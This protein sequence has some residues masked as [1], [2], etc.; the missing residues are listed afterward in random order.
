MSTDFDSLSNRGEYMSAHYFAEQMGADLRKTLFG[1]WS[2]RETDKHDPRPTPREMVRSLRATYLSPE[3]RTFFAE[4]ADVDAEDMD[5]TADNPTAHARLSTY[6]DPIWRQRLTDWHRRVL[7]ALGFTGDS[8]Q[9]V[10]VHRGG[11]EHQVEVAWRDGDLLALECGWSDSNDT[12]LDETRAGLTLHPPHVSGGE[13]Y[14]TGQRLAAWLFQST[15]DSPEGS[16]PRFVLLLCGGVIVL[17]DRHTWAEGRYLAANLDAA[18]ERYD[19][20]KTGE[21]ATIAALFSRDMLVP[22]DDGKGPLIDVL[23]GKSNDNAIGVT[24][25]LR[26]GL[27]LSVEIIANEVLDRLAEAEVAPR[28]IE[29]LEL[30]FAQELTRECLRYLY[31][32]LFLLYAEARPE[33]GI[34]PAD[35]GTY[36]AGY[37]V[38]RLRDLV[39]RDEQ[40]VEEEAKNG[41][42]LFASLEI[43]FEKVNDGHRPYGTEPDDDQPGDDEETRRLKAKR[44]S[45]GQGLRFE[46][47]RSKL[48]EP[49]AIRLIGQGVTDPRDDGES[50]RLDLRLRNSALHEVLRLLTMKKAQKRGERG[51]FISYRNL[52][53]NQ[54]G[55]VYESLMSYTGIIAEEE[56]CEVAKGGKP[57]KG[58]WLIPA[59]QQRDHQG[60][61]VEYG[62]RDAVKGLRGVKRY[63]AGT[64]V[65]RLAGRA[66]E[67]S[68]SYYTPESLTKV[69]VELALK[70][71]LDQ[72]R[73]TEGEIVRTRASELLRYKICEPALGSGAFLN[74]AINQVAEEYLRRRQ[75]ELGTSIPTSDALAEKQKVKAY[76]ALHNAYGVDLNATG[77]ELAEVSLWLNTMHP[78]MRAP[79]FGLHLRRGNSLVGARRV[80][81][82][83]EEVV[84]SKEWLRDKNTLAPTPLPFVAETGSTTLPEDAVHQFLLPSPGWASVTRAGGGARKLVNELSGENMRRLAQW[85]KDILRRPRRSMAHLDKQGRPKFDPK[86]GEPKKEAPSQ[87]TRL[88]D[89]ARK[90]E[91]LWSLVVKRMEIS[92]NEIARRIDVWGAKE[93]DPEYAFLQRPEGAVPK[94]KVYKDLFEAAGTP[95]WRLKKV[96]DAWCALWFW[97]VDK[98]DLLDGTDDEYGG[99]PVINSVD[100]VSELLDGVPVIGEQVPSSEDG[101][102]S[103]ESLEDAEAPE[104]SPPKSEPQYYERLP[105]FSLGSEQLPLDNLDPSEESEPETEKIRAKP[106]SFGKGG[107]KPQIPQRRPKIPLKDLDDWLDFLEA[108]LGVRDIPEGTLIDQLE[109]LDQLQELEENL[110]DFMGMEK[111]DPE[112]HFPWLST[113][114]DITKE[115]GFL[116]WE[117][118]FALVFAR[119]GGFDLQIGNPPWVRPEWKEDPVLAESDPWFVLQ[120]KPQAAE[121]RERRAEELAK[122]QVRDRLLREVTV[123]ATMADY[124]AAPQVYPL[125][126]GSQPDLY[127]A[128][129]CQTWDHRA[130]GGTVGLIH[131]DT[132]FKGKRE[133][134]LREEAYRRLRIHADF[135]NAG[136]RFFPPPVGRS[137]HFGL[138]IYG[139][140]GEIGFDHLSWLFSVESLRRSPK[141]DGSGDA[142]GVK[143]NGEWDERPHKQRVIRVD[144]DTLRR[145]QRLSR[146]QD[147]PVEQA[148]LLTPVSRAEDPAIDALAGYPLRLGAFQRPITRGFDESG[149]KKSV[150]GPGRNTPLIDYN[151]GQ[152]EREDYRA[153]SWGEVVLKGPQIGVANP[154]FKQPSQG[155]GELRGLDHGKIEPNT[156]PE[157]EYRPMVDEVTYRKEQQKWLDESLFDELRKSEEVIGQT[158]SELA[159]SLQCDPTEV[160][161]EDVDETLKDKAM[162]P[163]TDFYRI[164]WRRQIAPDTERALYSAIIPPGPAHV[165]TVHSLRIP[166]L[167]TTVLLAGFWSSIP[168]DY[169]LRT[170]GCNDLQVAEANAMPVPQREHP[171]APALLLRTLRLNCLT[172]AYA[173]LWEELYDPQWVTNEGWARTWKG[174]RTQLHEATP[175]WRWET[176]LRTEYARR[177]ALVEIDALVAVW[178]GIDADTLITMYRARLP[179]TQGHDLVTWFDANERKI[180]GDRYTY[181]HGQEKK[182]YEQ[183]L[184]YRKDEEKTPV[185]EGY[186]VPFHKVDREQEMREAHAVFQKRLTAAIERGEWDPERQEVP[187]P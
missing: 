43:L 148:R 106:R 156:I 114:R 4:R 31:R 124:L 18:L 81:Y 180:A 129:M 168:M 133:A 61:L 22:A 171:L 117:L 97:P 35:D 176:P 89:A 76:I 152:K 65:Y 113:V 166:D 46:A 56:L 146:E 155:K 178:L 186:T 164:A 10:T 109:T 24:A 127:R 95:Y 174:M 187:A 173:D 134:A 17:A 139:G 70:H 153:D 104:V 150:Y 26:E 151:T 149:A 34:L 44:R 159:R 71:R 78:G 29:G 175:D 47:L 103:S 158:R 21:L 36:E 90:A 130:A 92:E 100:S 77:V 142:P 12:A 143:L 28:Q 5:N 161:E 6:G 3:F 118:D 165:H 62:E 64:F 123:T 66:R 126:A 27:Q 74:E 177:A 19:R 9:Q 16:P 182:H 101:R 125:I 79:W 99:R 57:E 179:I 102:A 42:H 131:P 80:V 141:H 147:V 33:L 52:G 85:R 93:G 68:A 45:E 138:H 20:R 60:R 108:M 54:L 69:T 15:L 1:T 170:T 119:N 86:T 154:L 157:S 72:E 39:E 96:L 122:P 140:R 144:T 8:E 37:S 83:A 48:F 30:D 7:K 51:G 40:L 183:F 107:R 73:D 181:G 98:V 87:F 94:E 160:A 135:V 172:T 111:T 105:L 185:P 136:N 115:Q 53:I 112:Q 63:P 120:E 41:F 137:S 55:A 38:A 13:S 110:Q 82:T 58:S 167:L 132:H 23:L 169:F 145:W 116:H 88:R 162:R 184:A 59:D 121:K 25:E 11:R 67:T 14:E 84:S 50:T 91:F 75:E 32:I 163:Y 2:S 49:Q 128:F